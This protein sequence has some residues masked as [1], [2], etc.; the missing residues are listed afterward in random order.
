MTVDLEGA[1][2]KLERARHHFDVLRAQVEPF[3]EGDAHRFSYEVDVD[4]GVYT[5]YVH[6]LRAPDPS[7][8][9]MVG[10]CLHNARTAL[11]YLAVRLY[12]LGTAQDPSEISGISFPLAETPEGFQSSPTVAS[13]KKELGLRGYLARI[14]EMQPFH[15]GNPSIWGY[16]GPWPVVPL[17]PAALNRLSSLD[18]IDKH[19][20][21]HVAWVG[22]AAL[23]GVPMSP[24]ASFK[25]MGGGT[26][27]EPLEEDAEVGTLT[28]G[29]PLPDKWEPSQ[30]E[31]KRHFPLEVAIDEPTPAKGLLETLEVCLWGVEAALGLFK[32]VFAECLPPRPVTDTLG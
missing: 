20:V 31:M 16:G 23:R 4:A 15:A 6:D 24:P 17:L 25:A 10:D 22:V 11:D 29:P 5:F 18:N 27:L 2:E 3:E 26:R 8:G 21:I 1:R 19:R 30:M 13:F 14:E 7:W 28:F 12:A 9:L 32:P